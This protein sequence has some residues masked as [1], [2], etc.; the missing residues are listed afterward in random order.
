M[1]LKTLPIEIDGM[2]V[3][4]L[5][6]IKERLEKEEVRRTKF[7]EDAGDKK[8]EAEDRYKEA[9]QDESDTKGDIITILKRLAASK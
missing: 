4:Q 6:A 8:R 3:D 9:C 2:N 7:R 5:K 1:E